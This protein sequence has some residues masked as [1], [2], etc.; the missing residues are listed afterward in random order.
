MDGIHFDYIRYP[1]TEDRLPRGAT[2]GY[3]AV[4]LARF[5]RVTGRTDTPDPATNSGW[6]GGGI[7]SPTSFAG[8]RSKPRRSIPDQDQRGA[9]P[10]GA[11]AVERNRLRG[12]GADAADLPGLA[13]VAEGR[14]DRSRPSDELRTRDR[15]AGARVVRRLD[16][17]GEEPLAW[18]PS[19]RWPGRVSEYPCRDAATGGPGARGRSRPACRRDVLLLLR[20]P[21]AA[22]R[23]QARN[24]PSGGSRDRQRPAGVSCGRYRWSQRRLR[25]ACA[26][27]GD[28]LD[29]RA[30]YRM[31]RRACSVQ[32]HLPA[33]TAV[34]SPDQAEDDSGRSATPPTCEPT[35][36]GSSAWPR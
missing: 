28:A 5:H 31:D 29:R 7:R 14:L 3:N 6:T 16:A 9:D 2:V 13:S 21:R 25:A 19:R 11:A 15:C 27:S 30:G 33:T 34:D 17:M 22:G 8:C 1:E 23:G 26:G 35:R 32:S 24:R 18:P 12:C 20:R 36:T 10:V 4:N